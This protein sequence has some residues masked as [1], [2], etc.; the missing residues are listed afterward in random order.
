MKKFFTSIF[1]LCCCCMIFFQSCVDSDYD[2]DDLNESLVLWENG[3]IVSIGNLTPFFFDDEVDLSGGSLI[4]KAE[5]QQTI[6]E[7]F[8][9]D[10]FDYF[11]YEEKGEVYPT[12]TITLEGYVYV[13]MATIPDNGNFT[14]EVYAVNNSNY[15]K[16]L[17]RGSL[18]NVSVDDL[19]TKPGR[20]I[21]LELDENY[22]EEFKEQNVRDLQL[23][24]KL[25]DFDKIE[26]D[27]GDNIQ[28]QSIKI[29]STG[30]IHFEL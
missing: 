26:F 15:S 22:I 14:I 10:F 8:S 21:V 29:V 6:E 24:F 13:D 16:I 5:Y 3:F 12:G 30:G 28:L 20:R 4:G 2:T 9:E 17:T 27:P 25:S 19:T 23:N 11:L 7:V 18:S 1:M